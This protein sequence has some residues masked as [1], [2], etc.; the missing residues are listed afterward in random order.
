M[1]RITG[2]V[3]L[4]VVTLTL[5]TSGAI[6]F[7]ALRGMATQRDGSIRTLQEALTEDYDRT[8]RWQV[9]TAIGV[10]DGVHDRYLSG[11][12][13]ESSAQALAADLVRDLRYGEEG[14]FWIDTYAG[15]N[16]VLLGSA[17][18]GTNRFDL[19]DVN[20]KFL[21]Q[22]IIEAG[23]TPGGGFTDYW[24][25]RAG[26]DE[27]LPKRGYSLAF[28]PWEWVIGTG[29][30]VDD[31]QATVRQYRGELESEFARTQLTQLLVLI[32]GLALS[33]VLA[34]AVGSRITRPI[35]V[36]AAALGEISTGDADLDRRLP[37]E[38]NDEVGALSRNYNSFVENLREIVNS[39]K[40]SAISANA[41]RESLSAA[42]T[43][44]AAAAEEIAA[45]VRSVASQ[46]ETLHS[47]VDDTNS[48]VEQISR[49]IE[50]LGVQVESQASAVEESSASVEEMIASIQSI[51]RTADARTTTMENLRVST[52]NGRREMAAT[53]TKVDA[54]SQ[55]V[56]EVLEVTKVINAIAAQTNL[57]AMNAAIEAAHAGDY[58]R[59]F[60]VVADEIRKLASSA[61]EN[62]KS[63]NETLKKNVSDIQQLK[64]MSSAAIEHY[65]VV[66]NAASESAGSF[67]EIAAAMSELASGAEEIQRAIAALRDTTASVQSGADEM[68]SG[69]AVVEGASRQVQS[70]S[71]QV[72]DAMQQIDGGTGEISSAMGELNESISELSA[73]IAAIAAQVERFRSEE[74]APQ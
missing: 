34:I 64:T 65:D 66:E 22:E 17:S 23:R 52:T 61:S 51:A 36:A 8:I 73:V 60:A 20:G 42:S 72:R 59:G 43:E 41:K 40:S 31:I 70:V 7:F 46:T 49:T 48:A 15:D 2:K 33:V 71:Q 54:L 74:G 57:L 19:Q 9:E 21:V 24:F 3:V 28:E 56:S 6:G 25:P 53:D 11:A 50:S 47:G 30:Y 12:L 63:I 45:T 67:S 29:N 39:I 14:Y 13:D 18:E 55:S 27:A 16:I 62:A 4:L 58:G 37:I 38:S 44:T 26:S 5:V 35:R 69:S 32:A 1:K 10:I 68:K